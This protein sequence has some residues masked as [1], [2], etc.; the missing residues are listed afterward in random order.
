MAKNKLIVISFLISLLVGWGFTPKQ[1]MAISPQ[2]SISDLG[3]YI[4]SNSFKLSYSALSDDP[5]ATTAQ[6][7][8]RKEGESFV[9]FGP[10]ISGASGEVE[11][12]GTQVNDQVQYYF[13]V[14]I[15]SGAAS[16]E[17]TSFYDIS[18]PSPVQDYWKERVSP[19]L[20]RLHWKNPGDED[21]SRVFI[22]RSETPSFTADGAHKIGETGGAPDAEVS[23]DNFGLEAEKEYYY[24]LRAVDNANNSA[25]LL[26]DTQATVTAGSVLGAS[27]QAGTDGK[28]EQLPK[29][30]VL[31][32]TSQEASSP[33]LTPTPEA[34]NRLQNISE[35][36]SEEPK[37]DKAAIIAAII[38]VGIL[39]SGLISFLYLRKR[40]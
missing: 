26:A 6:F 9:A 7:Y 14:E 30:E 3:E 11:V 38:T 35:E 32:E 20:Y 18:G 28:I 25:S 2:V 36:V 17:T 12:T 27:T 37:T 21:F 24:A 40:I 13:R 34:S 8:F 22:Y 10:A 33:T 16:D 29:E 4:N 39:A 15:N 5:A 19:G 1:V 23:W 31:S